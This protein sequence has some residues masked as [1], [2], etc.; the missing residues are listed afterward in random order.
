MLSLYDDED[1]SY[2]SFQVRLRSPDYRDQAIIEGGLLS[3]KED[4][5]TLAEALKV[6]KK[7]VDTEVFKANGLRGAPK[8]DFFCGAFEEDTPEYLECH[9]R[10]WSFTAYHWSGSCS[11]GAVVDERLRVHGISGLRVADGSIMPRVVG[12]NTNAAIIMIGEKAADMVL[13]D[14]RGK[15]GLQKEREENT[16]RKDE[17]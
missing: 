4:V 9:V 2:D 8:D 13:E 16:G 17:L 12:A 15:E 6:A 11:M 7:L 1:I 14:W 3:E 10:H 5:D